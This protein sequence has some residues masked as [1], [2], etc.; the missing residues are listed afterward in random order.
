MKGWFRMFLQNR[1]KQHNDETTRSCNKLDNT[2]RLLD[3]LPVHQTCCQNRSLI[4]ADLASQR[5]EKEHTLQLMTRI[6][7]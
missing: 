1:N 7:S 3:F 6:G 4:K 5:K 2:T